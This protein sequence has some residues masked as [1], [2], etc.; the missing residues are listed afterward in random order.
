[1]SDTPRIN[2]ECTSSPEGTCSAKKDNDLA[3]FLTSND[4]VTDFLRNYKIPKRAL[5]SDSE[6]NEIDPYECRSDSSDGH[7]SD[8][9]DESDE[10]PS[11][12]DPLGEQKKIVL[13][14]SKERYARKFF[15]SHV[16]DDVIQAQVLKSSPVPGN[17]FL[18][19][20]DADE[21]IEDYIW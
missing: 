3:Q 16:A 12:F 9:G 20:P 13:D 8:S 11:R 21:Y 6:D 17:A 15:T 10:G 1:M 2:K 7:L 5:S 19:P 4:S 14:K 18:S